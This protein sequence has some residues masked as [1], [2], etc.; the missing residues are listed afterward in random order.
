MTVEPGGILL[1]K[2]V[3]VDHEG[4][5]R[6]HLVDP[7]L[8]TIERAADHDVRG[9]EE[10]ACYGALEPGPE[11]TWARRRNFVGV[12]PGS[13]CRPVVSS[14]GIRLHIV[15]S[16]LVSCPGPELRGSCNGS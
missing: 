15:G 7:H 4:M 6:E 13:G 10:P 3:M 14:G 5:D 16:L 1:R 11:V 9:L 2:P 12:D 8:I